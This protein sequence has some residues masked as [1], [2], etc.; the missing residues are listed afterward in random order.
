MWHAEGRDRPEP[1][2]LQQAGSQQRRHLLLL[3]TV[4]WRAGTPV[5]FG[6]DSSLQPGLLLAGND[7]EGPEDAGQAGVGAG[8]EQV[9]LQ[10]DMD[11]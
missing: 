6:L 4:V 7:E 3:S 2:N 5:Q 8:T 10:Q 1:G 9:S 11:R